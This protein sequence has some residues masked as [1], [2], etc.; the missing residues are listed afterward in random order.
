MTNIQNTTLSLNN[1][2]KSF[3]DTKVLKDINLNIQKGKIISLLGKSGSGKS[4]LLNIIAGFETSDSGDMYINKKRVF[5]SYTFTQ[6]QHRNIGFVFQNYALFPHMNIF[7]N[8][9]FGI[10]DFPKKEKT[11]IAENLLKLVHL[12]GYEKRFPHELSGGQQQRIALIRS[13]ALNPEILLLDEPFSGIDAMVKCKI[14]KELLEILRQTNKTVIIVT[15]DI[16][17]AKAMSDEIIYIEDG[18]IIPY[19]LESLSCSK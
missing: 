16:D 13:L 1:I 11:N 8:I 10:D 6:P 19:D 9:T 14:Q 18:K 2:S 3:G 12:E 17:E 4:T 15:H 5:D 7:D